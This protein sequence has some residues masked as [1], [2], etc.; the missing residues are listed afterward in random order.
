MTTV[1][2]PANPMRVALSYDFAEFVQ[3]AKALRL[4]LER[5]AEIYQIRKDHEAYAARQTALWTAYRA[6]TR[7]RNRRRNR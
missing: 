6:K 5:L 2:P 3:A 4:S 1:P 7:R